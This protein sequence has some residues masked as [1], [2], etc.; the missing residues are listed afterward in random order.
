MQQNFRVARTYFSV[1]FG[2]TLFLFGCSSSSSSGDSAPTEDSSGMGDD[3]SLDDSKKAPEKAAAADAGSGDLDAS[4]DDLGAGDAGSKSKPDS[5]AELGTGTG[6]PGILGFVSPE[7]GVS[8][9]TISW[10]KPIGQDNPGA[11]CELRAGKKK[12]A[13]L[14]IFKDGKKTAILNMFEKGVGDNRHLAK[15][16]LDSKGAPTWK[17][18]LSELRDN[19]YKP[20]GKGKKKKTSPRMSFISSDGATRAD[21]IYVAAKKAVTVILKPARGG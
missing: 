7:K 6:T 20:R 10:T 15:I 2:A 13:F 19:G 11:D 4:S 9:T 17:R 5:S 12:G 14:C 18:W 3:L 8:V 1:F 21:V 16:T